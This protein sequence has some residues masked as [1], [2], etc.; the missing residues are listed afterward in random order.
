VP[1]TPPETRYV[2][3]ADG[4]RIAYQIHGQGRRDLLFLPGHVS[5]LDLHWQDPAFAEIMGAL[6]TF[7]RVIAVDRR[8]VG[9]S[10]RLSPDDLPPVEV[11]VSDVAAVLDEVRSF[12]TVLVGLDEGA[13]IGVLFAATH[14]ERLTGLILYGMSP[15][16]VPR[17]DMPWVP[18]AEEIEAW[19]DWSVVRYG[20]REQ[21]MVDIQET[22]PSR[23]GD[24]NYLGWVSAMY[25]YGASPSAYVALYRMS[26]QLDV[27]DV[28]PAVR[29]PTLVVH[30]SGDRAVPFAAAELVADKLPNASLVALAGEDH[31]PNSNDTTQI[32]E[33]IRDFVGDPR[34][35]GDTKRR[36]ATLLFTDIVGSTRLAAELG[37]R[38]WSALLE[39]HHVVVRDRLER[40][41]GREV[42]TTGDGFFATF[43]GP[44][45]AVRCAQAIST[46]LEAVGLVVR[47]GVHTGEVETIDGEVGGLA[48]HIAA[49]IGALAG[50]SEVLVSST[51]KDLVAGSGLVFD[52]RGEQV[53]KGVPDPWHLYLALAKTPSS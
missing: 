45:Q 20:S 38:E 19:L 2:S 52:D 24:E 22:S 40:H 34:Q 9:L 27:T 43:D 49:R 14:P 10:D 8:G 28:L 31:F 33:A 36:L 30:R 42:S 6:G 47:A 53:L 32:I 5:H 18:P 29:T 41:H 16:G 13:Q 3:A 26:M 1:A 48:V 12:D 37:D 51:V 44:A 11:L 21:A 35:P 23:A 46:G 50:P 39:R 7:A 25:R 15:S 17:S 4:T